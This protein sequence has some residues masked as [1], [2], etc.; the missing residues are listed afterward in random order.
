MKKLLN[1]IVLV[2]ILSACDVERIPEDTLSDASFWKSENDLKAAA[3]YLYTFLP[4]MPVTTDIWSDDAFATLANEISSGTRLAPATSTDYNTPYRLIRAAN[5]IIEKS[6]RALTADVPAATVDIYI[7]EARFFR[8]WAYFQLVQKFGDVPLI[9]KT[10]TENAPELTAAKTPRAEVMDAIYQDLDFAGSKLPTP[11]ARGNAAYGRITNTAAWGLKAQAAL[12][13]GTR[14]KFHSYGDPLK[15]LTLAAAAAKAV[16]DSKEHDLFANY[17]DLFQYAGE[18]RQNK[19]NMIVRQ[20]GKSTADN[21][22]SHNTGTIINGALNPT[23]VLVDSYLMKDGL[24]ISKSPLYVTPTSHSE[25]FVNRDPRLSFTVMKAG[26]PYSATSVYTIPFLIYHT[27]G[28]CFRKFVTP[29]DLAQNNTSFIDLPVMRFAEILLTYAEAKFELNG[30]IT[31]TDLDLSI[32]RLRTRVQ[33]PPLTNAFV[34]AN[35]LSMREEIRRER[36]VELAQ[37]GFRYW[38]LI[39]WKIAETELPKDVLGCYFFPGGFGTVNPQ[40]TAD[41]YILLQKAS[42][43]SF[44]PNRDYLWPLPLTELALNPALKQNQDW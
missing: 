13:E 6:P 20:Y 26:D 23:K 43:R 42:T 36:R 40:L 37:E 19:E 9:L 16:I 41:N 10:L 32:N 2:L 25:I 4:L 17:F 3:N 24:P 12:F 29:A 18:G 21:I 28:F 8:A 35:G 30:T 44:K 39:R 15:H 11:T 14:A 1:Y 5:N 22:V 34:Q 7:A 31:D 38:D 33:M 27:T